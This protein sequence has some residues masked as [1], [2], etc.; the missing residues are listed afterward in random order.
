MNENT[1]PFPYRP[2]GSDVNSLEIPADEPSAAE[3]VLYY[4]SRDCE[5]GKKVEPATPKSDIPRHLT[6]GG[7]FVRLGL[8]G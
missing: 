7:V 8:D 2:S 3:R 4:L 1:P 5:Q 6:V